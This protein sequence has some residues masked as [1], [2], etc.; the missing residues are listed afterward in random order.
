MGFFSRQN[1][2][3]RNR[4]IHEES[5]Q[6]TFEEHAFT[7]NNNNNPVVKPTASKS[8]AQTTRLVMRLK[9]GFKANDYQLQ[10]LR[11]QTQRPPPEWRWVVPLPPLPQPWLRVYRGVR[12]AGVQ[13]VVA[14]ADRRQPGIMLCLSV[15]SGVPVAFIARVLCIPTL[16]WYR[17][18]E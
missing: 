9:H 13:A 11:V 17:H 14:V 2:W 5:V 7:N 6:S 12:A 15:V 18:A 3:D 16:I 8:L 1:S 4:S 10:R